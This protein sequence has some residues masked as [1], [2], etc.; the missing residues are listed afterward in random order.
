MA[1][2]KVQELAGKPRLTARE[3]ETL[4]GIAQGKTVRQ[5]AA[6]LGISPHTV[7]AYAKGVHR[8][9]GCKTG[10]QAVGKAM[11]LGLLCEP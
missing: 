1:Q 3:L 7:R 10:A 2:G 9:L 5:I 11:E 6:S 8:K 4:R